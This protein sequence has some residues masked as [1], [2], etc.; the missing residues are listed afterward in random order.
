[1][2]RFLLGDKEI[3]L[4]EIN[5]NISLL[6]YLRE[7]IFLTGTKEGCASGDCGACTVVTSKL[8]VDN[9]SLQY[10][11]INACIVPLGS[12]HG[13]QIITVEH[14]QHHESLHNCQLAMAV[15]H[16]S[17]CGFCTPGFVMSLF[18]YLKNNEIPER[19]KILEALGGNL[20]RCTGYKSIIAAAFSMYEDYIGDQFDTSEGTTIKKLAQ[21]KAECTSAFLSENNQQYLMPRDIRELCKLLLKHPEA[22]LVAGGTDLYLEIT[23]GLK[24]IETLIDVLHVPQMNSIYEN[25]GYIVIGAAVSYSAAKATLVDLQP[26]LTELIERFGSMQIRNRGTL[27]GNIANASPIAD[28]PPVLIA[29][30]ANITLMKM[31][32][33]RTIPLE[34][35]YTGYK[36]TQLMPQEFIKD[37]QIPLNTKHLSLRAY[38]VSKRIDDDISSLC[39]AISIVREEGLIKEAHIAYGGMAEVPKRAIIC[40]KSML[41]KAWSEST[42]EDAMVCISQDFSP[43]S[44]FRASAGYRLSVA[45][46]LLKRYFLE[47]NG[48]DNEKF[49]VTHYAS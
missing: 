45:K 21:I 38:K 6:E 28:M 20:C 10:E 1:M 40:E 32:A 16:G 4:E 49:R 35:F 14:L 18:S 9:T 48:L 30:N 29:L 43:I 39:L 22:R 37:I 11:S 47:E 23:Q 33:E 34:D 27:G 17:Q 3:V 36:K 8:D 5:P 2:I 31:D 25:N 13:R 41:G 46:N 42:I 19:E 12:L 24:K 44:D 15:N 7:K 26:H